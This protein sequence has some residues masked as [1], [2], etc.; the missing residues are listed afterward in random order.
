[1]PI[2]GKGRRSL[3][4]PCQHKEL[5]PV[6]QQGQVSPPVSPAGSELAGKGLKGSAPD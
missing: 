1:M 6:Q 3:G 2:S 5:G 4:G